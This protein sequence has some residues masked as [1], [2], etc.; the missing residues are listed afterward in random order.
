MPYEIVAIPGTRYVKVVNK[1]NGEIKAKRTTME[2]AKAQIRLLESIENIGNKK[3][4]MEYSRTFCI[5]K[6]E[7]VYEV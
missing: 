3:W 5:T 6:M 7:R 4:K 1:I 2:K